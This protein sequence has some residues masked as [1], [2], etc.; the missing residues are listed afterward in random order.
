MSSRAMSFVVFVIAATCVVRS[1]ESMFQGG[2]RHLGVTSTTPAYRFD[3]VKFVFRT[4]GPIRSSA[5]ISQK[6]LYFGSGDGYLYAVDSET[7]NR[8]FAS[9]LVDNGIV[10]C[11]SDDGSLYAI[12]GMTLPD[13]PPG[14]AKRAVFWETRPGMV[15]KWFS[16]GVDEWIR[17]Y[18]QR[19]GYDVVDAVGLERL[20]R[21]GV[22]GKGRSVVIFADHRVPNE[23]VREESE[24]ALIRQYLNAG[25]KIVWLGPDPIAWKRDSLGKMEGINYDRST[26]ILGIRYPGKSLE[27]IGWYGAVATPEGKKWGGKGVVGRSW[28]CRSCA[29][30]HCACEGRARHGGGLGQELRGIGRDGPRTA[31]YPS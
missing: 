28:L 8:I 23:L 14:A 4:G 6:V 1:Q 22:A 10:C 3:D 7:G 17:E 21:E 11:G 2:P 18:F 19:E 29:G 31:L 12:Q 16:A 30:H 20:M 9:P 26:K 15:G 25:G 27:G 24:Q 5:V 13:P